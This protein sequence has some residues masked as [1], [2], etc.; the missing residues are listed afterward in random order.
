VE[1]LLSGD[2][3][4]A[5]RKCGDVKSLSEL[6]ASVNY[7]WGH[8]RVADYL[9]QQP[10]PHYEQATDQP[11]FLIRIEENGNRTVGKFIDREFRPVVLKSQASGK[12]AKS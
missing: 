3:T 11:G 7:P 9:A 5:L 8:Q 10:Y 1:P 6:I 2:R 12:R 4:L